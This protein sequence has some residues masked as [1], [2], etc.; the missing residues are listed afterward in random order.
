MLKLALLFIVS[1]FLLAQA[2][3]QKAAAADAGG[4][5]PLIAYFTHSGNTKAVAEMIQKLTGGELMEIKPV[6]PYP[7]NYQQCVDLAKKQQ[8]EN[9]RPAIEN[10]INPNDYS[11]IFLGFPNW[12][13]S[14]PMP[15]WTFVEQNGLNGA[16][17]APFM[18][19]G[20]GGTGH[21][22]GDL[23]KLCP[24]SKILPALSISGSQARNSQAEVERWL[25]GLDLNKN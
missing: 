22:P 3:P 10:K 21:A 18:T 24:K 17:I 1:S 14:M 11:V 12:W 15:V 8:Q 2:L 19:H 9:A 6:E 23:K 20:G 16:A 25:K 13:S 5:K 4:K 7:E